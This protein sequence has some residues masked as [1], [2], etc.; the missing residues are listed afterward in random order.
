[1]KKLLFILTLMLS[2]ASTLAQSSIQEAVNNINN[3]LPPLYIIVNDDSAVVTQE[4]IYLPLYQ[5]LST[6]NATKSNKKDL[7][8]VNSIHYSDVVKITV[9]ILPED[10]GIDNRNGRITI[11]GNAVTK[12]GDAPPLPT[13]QFSMFMIPNHNLQE[14]QNN[15]L[16]IMKEAAK[17]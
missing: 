17:E 5:T 13:R 3:L 12:T 7:T 14:I 16:Y 11:S 2:V 9:E 15:L 8:V 1:M 10:G 4:F 6:I